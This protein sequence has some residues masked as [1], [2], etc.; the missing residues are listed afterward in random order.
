MERLEMPNNRRQNDCHWASEE[1]HLKPLNRRRRDV[2]KI[3]QEHK[4][5]E[6]TATKYKEIFSS[7]HPGRYRV[8][9]HVLCDCV[10]L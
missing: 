5:Y 4:I 8:E 2:D 1:K 10:P 7:D 6:F 9:F 3:D